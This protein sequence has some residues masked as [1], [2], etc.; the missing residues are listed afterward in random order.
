MAKA[1]ELAR[2]ILLLLV[3]AGILGNHGICRGAEANWEL[4]DSDPAHSDFY[5]DKADITRS[6][7]GI[8]SVWAKVVYSEEGKADTLA[9][10]KHAKAYENLAYTLYAYDIDCKGMKSLLKRIIHYDGQGKGIREFNLAGKTPWEEIPPNSRLEM[11]TDAEC[12][13]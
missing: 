6:P 11:V 5:Y 12:R 4:L 7:A 2:G 1:R 8:L 9:L 13:N 10:L 3:V